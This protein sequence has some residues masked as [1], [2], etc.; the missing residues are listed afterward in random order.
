MR[1]L[2]GAAATPEFMARAAAV[3]EVDDT[4]TW[5]AA[6]TPWETIGRSSW[7]I[8]SFDTYDRLPQ[9]KAPTLIIHGDRDLLVPVGNGGDDAG[10]DR[11]LADANH[12]GRWPLFFWEKPEESAGAII[13]FLSRVPA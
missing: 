12:A 6:P 8:Q 7:P 9:I 2:L 3:L 10:A 11:R 4:A 5:L 1:Q 13:E